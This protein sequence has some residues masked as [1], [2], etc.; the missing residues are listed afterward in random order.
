MALFRKL[1]NGGEAVAVGEDLDTQIARAHDVRQTLEA[2]VTLAQG[3]LAKIPEVNASMEEGERR[4]S[5][6]VQRLDTLAGRVNDFENIRR[7]TQ[8]FETRVVALEERVEQALARE[9]QIDEHRS[10]IEE[11][12]SL[13]RNAGDTLERLKQES[14]AF[15]ELEGR[16]P[17]LRKEFQP[18]F[19]QQATLKNDLDALRAGLVTL[20]QVAETGRES[21]LKARAHAV[22][23]TEIVTELERK[24][25]PLS[26]ISALGKDTD[27]QLRTLNA[28]S[29]HVTAKVKALE[30]QQ[31]VVERALVESRRVHEM[32]WDMEV[33]LK[34][35]DEGS[36]RAGRVEETL[37]ALQRMQAATNTTLEE[38]SR[39]REN[40]RREVDQ[41]ERDAQR[42]IETVRRQLDQFAGNKQEI[43][44]VQERLRL[45]Q[46]GIAAA[47]T[48][49]EAVSAREQE[50]GQLLQRIQN[51]ATTVQELTASAES[52]QRKQS[53][54]GAL[55]ERLDAL[56]AAAKRTQWQYESLAEHRKDLDTLKS[57]IQT[58][59][60]TYEQTATLLDKLRTDK[61]E[62]EVFLDKAGSFMTQAS[63]FETK[64]D[65]LTTQIAGTEASAAKTMSVAEAVDDLEARLAALEPRTRIV[66]DLEG[67]LNALNALSSDV[68]RRLSDQ[69]AARAELESLN[70]VCDGI[71]A[72]V[73]DAQQKI[74]AVNAARTEL[75]PAI[76]RLARLQQD[77]EHTRA[78]LQAL[79]R[80]D[81]TLA[82]QDRRLAELSEASRV[83]SLEAAQR[84]ETVQGLHQEL[85]RA[86]TL[87]EQLVAELAQI[88]KQQRDTF[89]Q[90]EAADD[91]FS[92]LETLW[93]KLDHRRSQLTE[94]EQTLGQVDGRMDEL[95]RLADAMDRKIQGIVERE[96]VVEAVRRGIEGVHAL[97]QKSQADLEAI[98]ERRAEIARA[99]SEMERLRD[100]LSATQDRIAAI[101]NRRH[102]VDDVQRKADTIANILGDVQMTLDSVSEQKAMVDHV[103]AEL[104]R[105][106]YLVQEARGTM[107]ALQTER[108]VAQRI[109]EN[110]R[111][112]HARANGEDRVTA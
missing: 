72:Q 44:T 45:V 92:R 67:R 24:L 105:I 17:G 96:Q 77:L 48:R 60:S 4:A 20:T 68:D 108:D 74:T 101:E 62:V 94:A 55:E 6:L 51:I 75:E 71:A 15:V 82:A 97:G 61:R 43:E 65:A 36:K 30:D 64:V 87:R 27:T 2:L 69:L 102:V 47:E 106:E 11:M 95:R 93:K 57:E 32:V 52:L 12:V 50:L 83:L 3:H 28:L 76:D 46:S 86:G 18:L 23:A 99:T 13:A 70:V 16:L 91:Q 63:Q 10:A 19:D 22:K 35:L 56:E 26:Q 58:V 38:A 29:E 111:Q 107:R 31:S 9:R 79:Q 21:A 5:D 42:L 110:V 89:A 59:H 49:V 73:R 39:G 40:L 80:D 25:E 8:T 85:D 98:S 112:I 104:A 78:A 81:E 66:E 103:F 33:Q 88:Q 1:M 7:Q 84:L 54:L 41:Q 37:T 100:S 53:S 109:V 14:A 34:K 90:I